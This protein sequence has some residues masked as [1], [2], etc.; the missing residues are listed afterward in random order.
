MT[1]DVHVLPTT[2][3]W[4]EIPQE[5]RPRAMSSEGRRRLALRAMRGAMTALAVAL[6]GLAAWGAVA[7]V[8][9]HPDALPA[10]ARGDRVRNLI[11]L[12][13]GVLDQ[14]WLAQTL[15]LPSTATLMSLDLDRL[16]QAVLAD[17]QVSAAEVVRTFPDT[18]RVTLS[19][20]SPVA[21]LMAQAGTGAPQRLLVARDGVAFAGDG[22]DPAMV[23]TLPWIDGMRLRR[24]NGALLPIDGMK[25]VA[26]LLATAKLEAEN[27]Y[28][29]WQVVSLAR[30]AT[31]GELEVR[32][33][34]G[35]TVTFDA[36]E[37]F[38]RQ[39]GRLDL[40][41]AANQDPTR[42]LKTVNLALGSQV[43][44]S[45]GTAAPT[46][47]EGP[48]GAPPAPAAAPAAAAPSPFTIHLDPPREL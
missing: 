4:R 32:T 26:E 13:D 41:V 42:P 47:A 27:L 20:R 35:L 33:R 45:Y 28:R 48:A 8:R 38:L 25:A 39:I 19:E 16:R 10:A 17:P 44:V 46:L 31:D 29:R 2:R 40:L 3:T 18:L 43:A 24:V 23:A 34:D 22:F 11:L 12:T 37:D 15:A 7:V 14:K 21:R 5:V 9:R 6:V 1:R 30:L 36:K